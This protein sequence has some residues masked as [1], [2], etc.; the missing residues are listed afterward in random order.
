M[1][2]Y[3]Q[4]DSRTQ[5][6]DVTPSTPTDAA[7]LSAGG[8]GPWID[9]RNQLYVSQWKFRWQGRVKIAGVDAGPTNTPFMFTFTPTMTSGVVTATG[10]PD[11]SFPIALFTPRLKASITPFPI[12][13]GKLIQ[14]MVSAINEK[15]GTPA[16]GRVKVDG[17]DAGPTNT[18]IVS[19]TGF[20]D[21][22]VE[23]GLS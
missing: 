15:T 3:D 14:V 16:A 19:A 9:D 12:V 4:V 17:V 1:G 10:Y 21:A 13:I 6:Y 11:K 23:T 5:Y 2:V 7:N 22:V 20:Q 8:P 18:V